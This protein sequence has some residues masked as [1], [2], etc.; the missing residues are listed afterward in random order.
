MN[1]RQ[2]LTP[3]FLLYIVLG[4][5]AFAQ[6]VDIPD[7]NLRAAIAEALNIAHDTPAMLLEK[8]RII[9]AATH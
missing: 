6:V 8:P 1:F 9:G 5:P 3:Y 4:S 2:K 7:V